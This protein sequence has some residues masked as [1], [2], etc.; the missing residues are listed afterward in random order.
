MNSNDT[1]L[2]GNIANKKIT[3]KVWLESVFTYNL[4]F[5]V[6]LGYRNITFFHIGR[7]WGLKRRCQELFMLCVFVNSQFELIQR[8]PT[9]IT[10]NV[11]SF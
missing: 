7:L 6:Y 8:E 9:E 4:N 1:I 5:V 2:C 3:S 10:L 11:I